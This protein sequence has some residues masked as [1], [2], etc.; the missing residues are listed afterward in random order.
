MNNT[1]P[2]LANYYQPEFTGEEAAKMQ[3]L[4]TQNV[5]TSQKEK[6]ESLAEFKYHQFSSKRKVFLALVLKLK[7]QP[8]EQMNAKALAMSKVQDGILKE[9]AKYL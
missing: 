5:I 2:T 4:L 1:N 3:N 6:E 8:P 7:Q 9:I